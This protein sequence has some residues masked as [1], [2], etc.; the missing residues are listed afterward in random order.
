MQK[1]VKCKNAACRPALQT[2]TNR[3]K[4]IRIKEKGNEADGKGQKAEAED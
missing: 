1:R 2:N 3:C 4:S